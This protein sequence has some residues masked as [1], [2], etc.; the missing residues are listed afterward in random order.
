MYFSAHW[1]ALPSLGRSP[2]NRRGRLV[3]VL[4]ATVSRPSSASSTWKQRCLCVFLPCSSL[5]C[6][7]LP[8]AQMFRG[9][10]CRDPNEHVCCRLAAPLSRWCLCHTTTPPTLRKTPR[11]STT[12]TMLRCHGACLPLRD[13]VA[14]P[15][16]RRMP[17]HAL[18]R[19][20][21]RVRH[22]DALRSLSTPGAPCPMATTMQRPSRRSTVRRTMDCALTC[23]MAQRAIGR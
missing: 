14:L 19:G 18:Y 13:F 3:G 6:N 5:A 17:L 10:E 15:S 22:A 1:S 12:S 23:T 4:P 20:T 2:H 16:H 21:F 8:T 9:F 7:A 11:T